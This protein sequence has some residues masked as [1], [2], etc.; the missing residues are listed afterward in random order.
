M[1]QFPL[2]FRKDFIFFNEEREIKDYSISLLNP[3]LPLEDH[4]VIFNQKFEFPF[5]KGSSK[6]FPMRATSISR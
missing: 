4:V 5:K 6:T 1:S 3:L 2:Y